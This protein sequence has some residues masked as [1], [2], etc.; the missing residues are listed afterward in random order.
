MSIKLKIK[1]AVKLLRTKEMIPI[2]QPVNSQKLL[3]GKVALI[4]GGSGGI[5]NAIAKVFLEN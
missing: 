3:Q 4:T 2:P 1:N 5:G